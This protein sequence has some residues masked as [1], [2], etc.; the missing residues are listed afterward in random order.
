MEL[1]LLEAT[2]A[3]GQK[4]VLTPF[5]D[6][7]NSSGKLPAPFGSSFQRLSSQPSQTIIYSLLKRATQL[8]EANVMSN[9]L[10]DIV[11]TSPTRT[12]NSMFC[13]HYTPDSW[14]IGASHFLSA[15]QHS[16]LLGLPAS[17]G[18]STPAY[19]A[20]WLKKLHQTGPTSSVNAQCSCTLNGSCPVSFYF[21]RYVFFTSDSSHN[22]ALAIPHYS[23]W[24]CSKDPQLKI[25]TP[26]STVCHGLPSRESMTKNNMPICIYFVKNSCSLTWL[27]L[28]KNKLP[29][30]KVTRGPGARR[31]GWG[32]VPQPSLR[33]LAV[34]ERALSWQ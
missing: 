25:C 6:P 26:F 9:R 19:S 27:V 3:R 1:P 5:P 14:D 2:E 30:Y 4:Q 20:A 23:C 18:Y 34:R 32:G 7:S 29:N 22:S 31:G 28:S 21:V 10:L 33:P 13:P 11:N 12:A 15:V 17:A 24:L 16:Q 8:L